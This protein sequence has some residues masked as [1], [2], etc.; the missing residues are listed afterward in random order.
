MR[1]D[2][3]TYLVIKIKLFSLDSWAISLNSGEKVVGFGAS[4]R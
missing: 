4:E 3:S 1:A 2:N